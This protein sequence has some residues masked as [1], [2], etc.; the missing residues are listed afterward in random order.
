MKSKEFL[1]ELR[2]IIREEVSYAVRQELKKALNESTLGDQARVPATVPATSTVSR[3][4]SKK[5]VVT[6]KPLFK[7][8]ILNELL[9]STQPLV[10]ESSAG[11]EFDEWPTMQYGNELVR[12]GPINA[13]P[14]GMNI[15]AIEQSAPELAAAFTR[16]YRDLVKA[17]DKKKG[18]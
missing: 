5:P 8:P 9:S 6:K 16:D 2:M 1:S 14:A 15:K 13:T 3:T 4:V 18:R 7:D 12:Q 17:F 11:V 10:Q